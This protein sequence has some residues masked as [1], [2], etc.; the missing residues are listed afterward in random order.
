MIYYL[1]SS[2]AAKLIFEEEHSSA[3]VDFL[4]G[5]LASDISLQAN[6]RL[7]TELRRAANGI[8]APQE[9]VTQVLGSVSLVL[10]DRTTFNSAGLL[11]GPHLRSLDAIHIVTALRVAADVFVTY[12]QRQAEAAETVG[13]E[14][15][16]PGT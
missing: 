10:P 1:D 9:K 12:D 14:V 5:G 3:L 8:D 4:G 15:Q 13:L 2:A 7:E 16:A 11:F 6:C